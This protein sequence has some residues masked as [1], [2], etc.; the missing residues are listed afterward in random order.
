MML[1]LRALGE[2]AM[3]IC[4]ALARSSATVRL[5]IPT[6]PFFVAGGFQMGERVV[7]Q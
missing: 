6:S 4:L 5:E 7:A 2:M 3:P 1:T